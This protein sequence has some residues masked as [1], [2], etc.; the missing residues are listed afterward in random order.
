MPFLSRNVQI[1]LKINGSEGVAETLAAA[2]YT[3]TLADVS[4]NTSYFTD[5][6]GQLK[7]S[8][9]PTPQLVGHPI[10]E[11]GWTEELA[12]GDVSTAARWENILRACGFRSA[13]V[14]KRVTVGSLTG[15]DFKPNDLL[16]DNAALGSATKTVR[17]ITMFTVGSDTFVVYEPLT[18][19][20]LGA[21]DTLYAYDAAGSSTGS[22]PV[23]SSPTD[24]GRRYRPLSE[25]GSSASPDMTMIVRRDG[26]THVHPSV[27]G[28]CNLVFERGATAKMQ[29]TMRGP[30]APESD[31]SI[32]EAGLVADVPA[33]AV[34]IVVGKIGFPIR[35]GTHNPVATGVTVEMSNTLTDRPTI[36]DNGVLG[37][38]GQRMGAMPTRITDRRPMIKVPAEHVAKAT[39]DVIGLY[40]RGQTFVFQMVHGKASD[41]SG[42]IVVTAPAAQIVGGANLAERDGIAI[43]DLDLLC[44]GTDDNE[45]YVDVV[46]YVAA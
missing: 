14:L 15:T 3:A 26:Q 40:D 12:G 21:S 45:L 23:D 33:P 28:N 9:S 24:A 17:F 6:R 35:L 42:R 8:L 36:S 2:D 29:V 34:P 19:S 18:G 25:T 32:A 13:V 39:F 7:G 10:G 11:Y 43:K 31:G 41:P 22:R 27:R 1:G 30:K 44:T 4:D 37:Y 20:A 46:Y 5:E 38:G 16:G